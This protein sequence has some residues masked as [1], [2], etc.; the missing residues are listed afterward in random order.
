L[1]RPSRLSDSC[2]RGFNPPVA[3]VP[4]QKFFDPANVVVE[5]G[6]GVFAL[7]HGYLSGI[8][9]A[10]PFLV[11][12]AR[13]TAHA[14][15]IEDAIKNRKRIGPEVFVLKNENLIAREKFK[16]FLE[17]RGVKAAGNVCV[18]ARPFPNANFLV[19]FEGIEKFERLLAFLPPHVPLR[20]R[21]PNRI[22]Q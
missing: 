14:E 2:N 22:A 12:Q 18:P 11:F 19:A 20:K 4:I 8:G 13:D 15:K 6:S 7:L 16:S 3:A 17:L 21:A 5:N 1:L 10:I 9:T